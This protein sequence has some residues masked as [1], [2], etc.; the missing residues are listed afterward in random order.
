MDARDERRKAIKGPS[1]AATYERARKLANIAMWTIALQR[2]RLKTR[3]PEDG[4]FLFRRWADFQFL[5]VALTRLRRAATLSTKVPE[6]KAAMQNALKSFD[7][8]LPMLKNM[9]DTAEHFDDYALDKG[10]NRSIERGSLEMGVIGETEFE[11]LGYKL[12][13]D[14]AASAAQQLFKE[15][16]QAQSLLTKESI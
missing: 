9:R 15:I 11:W 14:S 12:N 2:R 1:D 13:A 10:R 6:L 8:Q 7:S 3:E 5:I 4:E 16:Q